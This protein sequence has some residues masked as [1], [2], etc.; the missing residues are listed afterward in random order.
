MIKKMAAELFN[1]KNVDEWNYSISTI[2]SRVDPPFKIRIFLLGLW[3]YSASTSITFSFAFPSTGGAVTRT[4]YLFSPS[5]ITSFFFD[6]G[7]TRMDI[8][9]I[10]FSTVL[11]QDPEL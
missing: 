3:K 9:I 7:I 4:R 10:V 1:K 6:R 8:F 5:G 2:L 11:S